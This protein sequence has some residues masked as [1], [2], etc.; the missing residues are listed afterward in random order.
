MNGCCMTGVFSGSRLM[1]VLRHGQD[2]VW[3]RACLET[4]HSIVGSCVHSRLICEVDQNILEGRCMF[5]LQ[6]VFHV[7]GTLIR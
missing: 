2:F 6:A 1:D 7:I 4:Q 3:Y 5:C